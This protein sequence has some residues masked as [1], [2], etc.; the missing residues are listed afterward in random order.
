MSRKPE[1]GFLVAALSLVVLALGWVMALIPLGLFPVVVGDDGQGAYVTGVRK[2][3]AAQ[4]AGIQ[5]GDRLDLSTL[6]YSQRFRLQTGAAPGYALPLRVRHYG[7]WSNRVITTF[8]S[9]LPLGDPRWWSLFV[10]MTVS[11]LIAAVVVARRPSVAT[12]AFAFYTWGNLPSFRLEELFSWLPDPVYGVFAT[13]VEAL[14][15]EFPLFLLLI[16]VT[17]FPTEPS[18]RSGRLRMRVADVTLFVGLGICFTFAAFEPVRHHTWINA[19]DLLGTVVVV[20]GA[21]LAALQYR[22]ASGEDRRRIGWVLAGYAVSLVSFVAANALITASAPMPSELQAAVQL[23]N[24]ALPLALAYAILRHRVLDVGFALN[25]TVIYATVT[26]VVVIAVSFVDWLAGKLIGET[27]LALA[28]EAVVTIAIGV[29]LNAMHQRIGAL[30][31]RVLFRARH[32]AERRLR[33]GIDALAF[34]ASDGAIERALTDEVAVALGLRSTALFRLDEETDRFCCVRA[35][36]WPDTVAPIDHDA[37]LVRT[38]RL[39]ERPFHLADFAIAEAVFLT[40]PAAPMI[41]VPVADRHALLGFVL[42]GALPDGTAPDPELVE[43]LGQLG[44][45]AAAASAY[46]EARAARVRLAETE[47]LLAGGAS[48]ASARAIGDYPSLPA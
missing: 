44:A 7:V 48:L 16:F 10:A 17:R 28:A 14:I 47:Q 4:A 21:L 29:A 8:P 26:T 3:G 24:V 37:L 32:M 40:G 5:R 13:V 18:S 22:E 30:V 15:S 34:A 43:L 39:R 12:A 35:T 20:L 2:A 6:T 23:A 46:V 9:S 11:V 1:F 19:G 38:L 41:A 31:D 27:R 25:R 42:Y 33:N 45:A 36:G